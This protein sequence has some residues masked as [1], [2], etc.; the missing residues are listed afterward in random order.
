[1][2]SDIDTNLAPAFHKMVDDTEA[3]RADLIEVLTTA[4]KEAIYIGP[5]DDRGVS[6]RAARGSSIEF[7]EGALM[8]EWTD[9]G[10]RFERFA[11]EVGLA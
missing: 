7:I 6:V 11:I 1:M 3:L 2:S 9:D 5:E 8:V 10:E 4:L